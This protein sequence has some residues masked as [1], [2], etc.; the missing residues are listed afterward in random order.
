MLQGSLKPI[1]V[2]IATEQPVWRLMEQVRSHLGFACPTH[3]LHLRVAKDTE[4]RWL[5]MAHYAL[6]VT[7]QVQ[8]DRVNSIMQSL[9]MPPTAII[10]VAPSPVFGDAP[11]LVANRA[12]PQGVVA[13]PVPSNVERLP[14]AAEGEHVVDA[15]MLP[16]R[17]SYGGVHDLDA[18]AEI[19]DRNNDEPPRGILERFISVRDSIL[20]FLR[21]A[22]P[23][24][25]LDPIPPNDVFMPVVPGANHIHVLVAFPSSLD[26]VLRY[27]RECNF[28]C[29]G[30]TIL[31]AYFRLTL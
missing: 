21:S 26:V 4:G 20:P 27:E 11:A 5:D 1:Y 24:R 7:K 16:P 12:D 23:P 3:E 29:F 30:D 13:A 8:P 31:F 6:H 15:A 28:S 2:E 9:P 10:R 18:G 17:R 22:T 19:A 14:S 25:A